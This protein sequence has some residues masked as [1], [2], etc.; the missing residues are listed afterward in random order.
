MDERNRR[1]AL[2][3]AVFRQANEALV[4]LQNPELPLDLLCECGRRDCVDKIEMNRPEYE[5]LRADPTLFAVVRGHEV[6]GV[7]D[8]VELADGYDVVQKRPET[9]ELVRETDP[10]SD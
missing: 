9:H 6:Q 4:S 1:V 5:Q 3:E 2:N 7:E 8:V 10:R